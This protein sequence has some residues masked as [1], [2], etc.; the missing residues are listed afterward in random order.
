M[1]KGMQH[2]PLKRKGFREFDKPETSAGVTA[3]AAQ[4]FDSGQLPHRILPQGR[5]SLL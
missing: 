2:G 1:P 3:S 4:L 5:V